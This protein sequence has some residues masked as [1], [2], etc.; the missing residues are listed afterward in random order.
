M[1]PFYGNLK[2]AAGWQDVEKP[3][4]LFQVMVNGD[5]SKCESK[6]DILR[7]YFLKVNLESK[8]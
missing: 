3:M 7:K 4:V 5:G 6:S 2:V 1:Q 8:S